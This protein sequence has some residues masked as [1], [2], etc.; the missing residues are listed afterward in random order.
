MKTEKKTIDRWE[1]Q[2]G[3]NVG[4][5]GSDGLRGTVAEIRKRLTA[6]GIRVAVGDEPQ[7]MLSVCLLADVSSGPHSFWP[8]PLAPT[9]KTRQLP[10][11]KCC[12]LGVRDVSPP[13]GKM[14]PQDIQHCCCTSGARLRG[15]V[16]NGATL[17]ALLHDSQCQRHDRNHA[18]TRRKTKKKNIATRWS[19]ANRQHHRTL[20]HDEFS[21]LQLRS[22]LHG[23]IAPTRLRTRV[24]MVQNPS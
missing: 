19:C 4:T 3:P 13:T 22:Q 10:N 8:G 6:G 12:S 2:A 17:R 7:S 18:R 24:L 9:H 5:K 21:F 20:G 1:N 15:L 11:A 23:H 16:E 14:A